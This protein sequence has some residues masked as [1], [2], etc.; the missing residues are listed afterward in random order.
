MKKYLFCALICILIC[1][2]SL[3]AQT[4]EQILPS[5]VEETIKQQCIY[6]IKTLKE[7]LAI[8]ASK[9]VADSIKD[10]HI[11]ACLDL[12]ISKGN[13]TK[14]T[15]GNV[16]IHA[17]RIE[18]SSLSTGRNSSYPLKNYLARLKRLQYSEIVLKTSDCYLVEG[19]LKKLNDRQYSATVSFYQ[20]FI[21]YNGD[22][23]VYRD[24]MKKRVQIILEYT[25]TRFDVFLG[26]ISVYQTEST[27][28]Q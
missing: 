6:K 14:D 15:E 19:D 20:V 3:C 17:P 28:E 10:Y 8:I 5:E 26:D 23:I 7:H 16:I 18:V 1:N 13:D 4:D 12:F 25:Q 24:K 2:L 22:M 27:N 9:E 21:G 11:E